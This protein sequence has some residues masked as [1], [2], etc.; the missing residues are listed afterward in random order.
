M[1]ALI[2]ESGAIIGD[3]SLA[4]TIVVNT[5]GFLGSSRQEALDVIRELA[6]RKRRGQ[7]RRLRSRP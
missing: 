1:L 7:L 6:A 4:D 3:E 5:C 2:A